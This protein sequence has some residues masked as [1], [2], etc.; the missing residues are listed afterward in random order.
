MNRRALGL[1]GDGAGHR[2]LATKSSKSGIVDY[3]PLASS[4]QAQGPCSFQAEEIDQERRTSIW[5]DRLS[6]F[7]L[8]LGE[9]IVGA[10]RNQSVIT[11]GISS[12]D[13]MK[14]IRVFNVGTTYPTSV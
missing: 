9:T 5:S 13:S 10:M 1:A 12:S 4:R 2:I 3:R 14:G 8:D 7:K 11:V 6:R